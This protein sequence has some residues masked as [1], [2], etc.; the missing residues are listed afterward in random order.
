MGRRRKQQAVPRPD[1]TFDPSVAADALFFDE[2]FLIGIVVLIALA[3]LPTFI[4]LVEVLIL[5]VVML[6]TVLVR[7]LFRQPWIVDAT[8]DDGTHKA[9]KVTGY[10]AS[11]RAVPEIAAQLARG[12]Q[13][14]IARSATLVR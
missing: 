7:V 4:F 13:T 8:A 11:R 10:R 5:A 9:W 12:T 1:G 14:P 6:V 3:I 2:L